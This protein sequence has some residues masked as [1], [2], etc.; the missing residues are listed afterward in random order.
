MNFLL[1]LLLTV[2]QAVNYIT[3]SVTHTLAHTLPLSLIHTDSPSPLSYRSPTYWKV[4]VWTAHT[5]LTHVCLCPLMRDVYCSCRGHVSET[6]ELWGHLELTC[7]ISF[8]SSLSLQVHLCF[9]LLR[10]ATRWRTGSYKQISSGKLFSLS[11]S[12]F[13]LSL[14]CS[15]PPCSPCCRDAASLCVT[16]W[17]I[18]CVRIW[19]ADTGSTGILISSH[20]SLYLHISFFFLLLSAF[21][22]ILWINT[23]L[24]FFIDVSIVCAFYSAVFWAYVY[25]LTSYALIAL[26]AGYIEADVFYVCHG[27]LYVCVCLPVGI[28]RLLDSGWRDGAC[29]D[30]C[31]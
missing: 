12:L 17:H 16:L 24:I 30:T 4:A 6:R 10:C 5:K 3:I 20:S 31:H 13:F 19:Q 21:F 29:L 18:R 1:R 14:S 26:H 27:I 7:H 8:L 2:Y 9:S 22:F 15:L 23:S 25:L 28:T 11:F